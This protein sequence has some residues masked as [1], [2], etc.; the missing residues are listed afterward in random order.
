MSEE[1]RAG[2]WYELTFEDGTSAKFWSI[3][4]CKH[5]HHRKWGVIGSLGK[6]QITAFA[7][8]EEAR[9]DAK[10]LWQSKVISG[11]EINESK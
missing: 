7:N 8:A 11:W 1:F 6:M 2:C 5:T 10:R 3:K 9:V 4:I